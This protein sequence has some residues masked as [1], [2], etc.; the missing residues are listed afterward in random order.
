M[1]LKS[2]PSEL[3][4]MGKLFLVAVSAATIAK[5]LERVL[6][7]LLGKKELEGEE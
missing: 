4:Q 3:S 7:S 2:E 5:V 6:D 1:A